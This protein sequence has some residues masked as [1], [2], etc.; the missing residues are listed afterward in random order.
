MYNFE[1]QSYDTSPCLILEFYLLHIQYIYIYIY[2]YQY[3]AY[4]KGVREPGRGVDY[5]TYQ[6]KKKKKEYSYTSTPPLSLHGHYYN[7][8]CVFID[9]TWYRNNFLSKISGRSL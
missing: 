8:N 5:Q 4:F 6:E 9:R 2:T 7:K 3:R 1:V